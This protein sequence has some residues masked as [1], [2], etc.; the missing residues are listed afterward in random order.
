MKLILCNFLDVPVVT[1]PVLDID[2]DT[3]VLSHR[4]NRKQ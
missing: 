1:S 4:T 2:T 3:H